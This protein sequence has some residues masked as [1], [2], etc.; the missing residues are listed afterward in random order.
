[1]AETKNGTSEMELGT[2][3]SGDEE[4]EFL[5]DRPVAEVDMKTGKAK[6]PMTLPELQHSVI[7]KL[8]KTGMNYCN[9]WSTL[10]MTLCLVMIVGL[11]VTMLVR[12]DY[13]HCTMLRVGCWPDYSDL[14]MSVFFGAFCGSL[15]TS[16]FLLA[17]FMKRASSIRNRFMHQKGKKSCC[18]VFGLSVELCTAEWRSRKCLCGDD[19]DEYVNVHDSN[20][21]KPANLTSD[22]IHADF[23]S[24]LKQEEV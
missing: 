3:S 22:M 15:V 17:F 18:G 11:L 10:W 24:M 2:M 9:F 8:N 12:D 1:M 16:V 21:V 14:V 20:L 7:S 23:L 5:V 13:G 19:L 6:K 4:E